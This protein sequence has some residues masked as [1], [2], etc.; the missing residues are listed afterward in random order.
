MLQTPEMA[1]EAGRTRAV[2][3]HGE[4]E[5]QGAAMCARCSEAFH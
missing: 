1:F 2:P 5:C 3:Q 4:R